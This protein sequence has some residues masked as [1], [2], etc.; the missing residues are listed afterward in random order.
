MLTIH[1]WLLNSFA[2]K[3]VRK[4]SEVASVVPPRTDLFVIASAAMCNTLTLWI[5][6]FNT[7][8]QSEP[9]G[10]LSIFNALH[11]DHSKNMESAY[12]KSK[13]CLIRR[14]STFPCLFGVLF[15]ICL[16]ICLFVCFLVLFFL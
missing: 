2:E 5:S 12:G 3:A 10:A 11:R 7:T 13:D 6:S 8:D 15:L 14:I 9:Q 4:M 16:F 1:N